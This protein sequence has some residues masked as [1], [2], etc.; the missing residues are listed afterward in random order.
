M[1]DLTVANRTTVLVVAQGIYF[2]FVFFFVVYGVSISTVNE[3]VAPSEMF[4]AVS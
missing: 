4:S 2:G 3:F 1:L